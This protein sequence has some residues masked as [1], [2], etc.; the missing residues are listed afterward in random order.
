MWN[1]CNFGLI[2]EIWDNL[3]LIQDELSLFDWKL[4]F[5]LIWKYRY[6][7]FLLWFG[8]IVQYLLNSYS[9]LIAISILQKGN[10]Y[11]A[12]IIGNS[13]FFMVF[14]NLSEINDFVVMQSKKINCYSVYNITL[15][16]QIYLEIGHYLII[17]RAI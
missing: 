5:I 7:I 12:I 13:K 1:S 15:F 14:L 16:F 17:L 11:V 9:K 10:K 8:M 2:L 6:P 4:T 3:N